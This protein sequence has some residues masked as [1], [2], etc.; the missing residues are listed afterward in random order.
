MLWGNMAYCVKLIGDDLSHYSNKMES[1][2]F[3]KM[4][5]LSLSF[6]ESDVTLT[7]IS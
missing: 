3:K 1:F 5:V 7:N 4:S 6:Y 2:W